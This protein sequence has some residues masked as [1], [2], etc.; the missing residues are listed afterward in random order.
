MSS[1]F[2]VILLFATWSL[3]FPL[4][5]SLVSQASPL[6]VTALR[7]SFAG[8]ALIVYLWMKKG[9]KKSL[10]KKEWLSIIILGFISIFLTNILEFYSLKSLS[11]SKV[12]FLYSLSP[13]LTAL[14]SYFHFKEKMTKKK[15]LGMCIAFLAIAIGFIDSITLKS[16]QISFGWPDIAMLFAVLF[17]VYGWILL[18]MLVKS[19]MSHIFAN[20]MSMIIGGFLA[21][22]ISSTIEP[23]IFS[24]LKTLPNTFYL[25]ILLITII[26]NFI[27]YNLYGFLLNRFTATFMS[28]FGLL[29]PIFTSIH[30]FLILGEVPSLYI[31]LSTPC[32]LLGLFIFYQEELKQGYVVKKT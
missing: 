17:S 13:F 30:S 16:I 27:C 14:F 32:I 29:S 26:S 3:A 8:L 25:T 21:L 31:L 19:S 7:M 22:F 23:N 28:F 10:N 9:L 24:T 18:R 5:K 2:L 1:I 11:A 15:W 6:F 12:C 20:A 4:G